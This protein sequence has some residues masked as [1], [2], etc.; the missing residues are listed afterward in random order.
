MSTDE[1]GSQVKQG[2]YLN[3]KGFMGSY[4]VAK[5]LA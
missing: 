3:G 5:K 2:K 1:V 4:P